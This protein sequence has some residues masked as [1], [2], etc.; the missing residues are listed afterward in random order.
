MKHKTTGVIAGAWAGFAAAGVS[1]ATVPFT[2]DFST[3]VSNWRDAAG[4]DALAWFASGGRDRG[5]YV[6]T[7][8]L[9]PAP[10][11][12]LGAILFRAQDEYGSSGGAFEG[13]WIAD[14][15][16][17]FS[18]FIRHD[19][20]VALGV[21]ARFAGPAN[22]PGAA[23][24]AFAPVPPGTWTQIVIPISPSSPNIFLEGVTYEQVFSDIGHVQ[25]GV[26]PTAELA[27]LTITVDLDKVSIVPGPW[28]MALL[29]AAG[30]APSGRRRRRRSA[31]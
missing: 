26:S 8:Y 12:A 9:V 31:R 25:V 5:A 24:V 3:G 10:P 13:N 2:E 28:A 17:E 20:P 16:S 23:G 19:A 11:P 29:A 14:G 22:F 1:G 27:G 30:L 18:F 7:T 21:F 4:Q 15:V 6:S